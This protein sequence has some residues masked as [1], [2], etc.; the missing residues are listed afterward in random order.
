MGVADWTKINR[1][2]PIMTEAIT[3]LDQMMMMEPTSN[4]LTVLARVATTTPEPTRWRATAK[5]FNFTSVRNW[6]DVQL[7]DRVF[8]T[9]TDFTGEIITSSQAATRICG[10]VA[11]WGDEDVRYFRLPEA[12]SMAHPNPFTFCNTVT[13]KVVGG[14]LYWVKVRDIMIAALK[15][16]AIRLR[17]DNFGI[18]LWFQVIHCFLTY[19]ISW[20]SYIL[21][22]FIRFHLKQLHYS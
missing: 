17:Q 9:S 20:L 18:A 14:S 21:V 2:P 1:C 10:A 22:A 5:Y 6:P 15:L 16:A 4:S 8:Y 19:F 7:H 3:K 11:G 13:A 12:G